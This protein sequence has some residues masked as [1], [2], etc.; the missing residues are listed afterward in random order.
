MCAKYVDYDFFDKNCKSCEFHDTRGDGF[1]HYC[2][3]EKSSCKIFTYKRRIKFKSHMIIKFC[4]ERNSVMECVN[5]GKA[6]D[7]TLTKIGKV[8]WGNTYVRFNNKAQKGD[9]KKGKAL[10]EEV[11]IDGSDLRVALHIGDEYMKYRSHIDALK[12]QIEYWGHCG[13]EDRKEA[14]FVY[15][16]KVSDWDD[17]DEKVKEAVFMI[18]V[19]HNMVK[20]IIDLLNRIV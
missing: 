3:Y 6:I 9:A 14:N 18:G 16:D 12:L 20:D 17:S 8:D 7:E 4:K 2:Q 10:H 13:G 11:F 1:K 5:L 19:F 15:A